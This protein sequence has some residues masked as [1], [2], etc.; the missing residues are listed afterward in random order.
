MRLVI[1]FAKWSQHATKKT[2]WGISVK[3]MDIIICNS[4]HIHLDQAEGV[5]LWVNSV[6]K[7][8]VL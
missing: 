6:M 1:L 3:R 8:Q 7:M 2:I 5:L 4:L